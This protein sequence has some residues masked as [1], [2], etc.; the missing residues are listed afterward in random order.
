MRTFGDYSAAKPFRAFAAKSSPLDA[1]DFKALH[2]IH[3]SPLAADADA[4]EGKGEDAEKVA[5]ADAGKDEEVSPSSSPVAKAKS[6]AETLRDGVLS[7]RPLTET[8]ESL[9]TM[10]KVDASTLTLYATMA[11][12][13]HNYV[14]L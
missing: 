4:G 5:D 14:L 10:A 11:K 1:V 2:D 9:P 13:V 8:F 12:V 7:L 6:V 3:A